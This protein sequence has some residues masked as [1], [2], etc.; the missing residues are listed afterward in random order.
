MTKTD[1]TYAE[2]HMGSALN[3]IRKSASGFVLV[4]RFNLNHRAGLKL[5]REQKRVEI[6][7]TC[8]GPAYRVIEGG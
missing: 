1:Q 5:A 7:N 8:F 2:R 3:R 4:K 6:I